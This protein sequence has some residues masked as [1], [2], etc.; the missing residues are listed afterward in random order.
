MVMGF[1]ITANYLCLKAPSFWP[2]VL[3][4]ASHNVFVQS[5]QSIFDSITVTGKYTNFF[6][7]EFG[8]GLAVAYIGAAI[9]GLLILHTKEYC[10]K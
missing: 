6:T 8:I 2:A 3:I 10:H 9:A 7:S 1:T 4:H 5:V